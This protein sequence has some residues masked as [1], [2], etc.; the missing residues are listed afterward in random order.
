M[1]KKIEN[2]K[3]VQGLNKTQQKVIKGGYMPTL[4]QFCCGSRPPEWWVQQYP[5]LEP[6]VCTSYTCGSEDIF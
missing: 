2:L 1:L 6:K 5:F 3:D 4:E